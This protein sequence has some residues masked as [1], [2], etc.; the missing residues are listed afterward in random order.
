MKPS[1]RV[2]LLIFLGFPSLLFSQGEYTG[3]EEVYLLN[4]GGDYYANNYLNGITAGKGNAGIA[5]LDRS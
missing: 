5:G 1:R 4:P 2:I 3:F